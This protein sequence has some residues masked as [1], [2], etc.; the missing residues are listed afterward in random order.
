[1]EFT[2]IL[3]RFEDVSEEADGG[4]LARCPVPEHSDSRPSLR[5]WFGDDGK[6]RITCRAGCST[7]LVINAVGLEWVDLF[8]V[9]GEAPTVP[10]ERPKLVET[11]HIA[12]LATYV[13]ITRDQ[14][15]D[16][17]GASAYALKRFGL[18]PDAL[19]E[20][21]VGVDG[22]GTKPI[23]FPFLSRSF[24][25]Y[26][27]L[28]VPLHDFDGV[29]RGLQGR[30]ITG[31]CPGRWLSLSNPPGHRW[32]PYG[33]FRGAAGY[34]ATLVTEGPGDALTA[35]S[36]GYDAVAI[37]GAALA[38][39]PELLKELADGLRGQL[40]VTA[41]DADSAGLGFNRALADGLRPYGIAVHTLAIGGG[42]GDITAWREADPQGF[43]R[44]F[45]AAVKASRP[46]PPEDSARRDAASVELSEATG[47]DTVSSDQGKEAAR[48]L[49]A[50]VEQYGE[51]DTGNAHAIVHWTQNRIK[52]ATGLGFYVWN[53]RVWE[54]SEVK[55]R[56]EIHRMG[57]AL[58]LVG[59]PDA[60]K[61]FAMRTRIDDMMTEL[62]SVP[63]VHVKASDFDNA[64]HLLSFANGTVDL[65]SGE[66]LAHDP[67]HMLTY[68]LDIDYR[69]DA[70]A[71]RW[72]SFLT[73]VFPGMPDMPDYIRRLVGY[74]ITGS[75][76]EQCFA[77]LWGKGKNGKSVFT[78]VLTEIFDPITT[79]TP[80]ATFED[81]ASGGIP[82]D[83]AALRGARLV[84]ASEGEN[85]KPM[86]EAVL[87]RVT[88]KDR[89][90]ARFLRQEFFQFRP[91]FLLMLATNH[92]P[93]FKGQDD[94]LWRR[95]KM[96]PFTRW[97]APHE[98]DKGMDRKLLAEAEGI[99]AWAVR[100]AVEW[101][102][103][104]L[105]DP[106]VI[107]Q[108]TQE[109][110]ETSDALAGFFP[111]VLVPDPEGRLNGADVFTSYLDWCEAENLPSRERWT[112]QTFYQAMEERG[113]TKRRGSKGMALVGLALAD[114]ST[115][116]A[117]PGI[118]NRSED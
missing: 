89:I 28:T 68:C 114:K 56:Q 18:A 112:R 92:K 76:D 42:A 57:A 64:P 103:E 51:T 116:P 86:S 108:A 2:D 7:L 104:G 118:F 21:G 50:Y 41:G 10:K 73:D 24:R 111:G 83:L 97:F 6:A 94:G 47:T 3:D 39:S 115:A 98:R 29:P 84:M 67:G 19:Y 33:V 45:H 91:T 90:S 20:L 52:W 8:N 25:A 36:V 22:P 82:N 13:D 61:P 71:D 79:T 87:K 35:V 59:K 44:S 12:A 66:L 93:K 81:K 100:G 74:G 99:A 16:S 11:G 46:V 40:V 78:D 48:L 55:V 9:T 32:L 60:A 109:Y 15:A 30:D 4:F 95:V 26:D 70:P 88:G 85:G 69:P 63:S 54:R 102:A 75:A 37:R 27:R 23:P 113:V 105:T 1:M 106:E 107:E 5:I 31:E 62:K 72:D 65:R 96:I 34:G 101:Y 80:F 49:A 110:K 38:G 14:L 17:E 53:G 77:V 43:A 117:G 58:M